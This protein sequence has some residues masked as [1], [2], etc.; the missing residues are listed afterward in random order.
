MKYQSP[1]MDVYLLGTS[2][3]ITTSGGKLTDGGDLVVD[4]QIK[5]ITK[6]ISGLTFDK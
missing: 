2:D 6:T 4:E 1:K 5:E 3:I